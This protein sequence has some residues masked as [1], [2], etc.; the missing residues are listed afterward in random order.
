MTT[1]TYHANVSL[2]MGYTDTKCECCKQNPQEVNIQA[3]T[4]FSEAPKIR[5]LCKGCVAF[6]V[7]R[8]LS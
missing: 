7:N 4:V 5:K 3:S 1:K 8:H 6:L 2:L